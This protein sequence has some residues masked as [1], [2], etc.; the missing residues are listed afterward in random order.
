MEARAGIMRG[1]FDFR[2]Q[3]KDQRK[4]IYTAN[5]EVAEG[6]EK[7]GQRRKDREERTEKKGQRRKDRE[8]RTEKKGQRRAKRNGDSARREG[9]DQEIALAGDDHGEG[10]AVGS[11]GEIAEGEAVKDGSGLR[12]RDGNVMRR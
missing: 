10:A 4:K 1:R 12:L 9:E 6:T 11:D 8:E 5:T 2:G 7:K 3:E